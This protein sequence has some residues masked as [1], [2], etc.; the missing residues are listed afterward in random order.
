MNILVSNISYSLPPSLFKSHTPYGL[1]LR[2]AMPGNT[3]MKTE[4]MKR[5]GLGIKRER[6]GRF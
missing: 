6:F 3:A 1:T 4:K 2:D 5:M